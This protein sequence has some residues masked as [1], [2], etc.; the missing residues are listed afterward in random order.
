M[1]YVRPALFA[2][3]AV[4]VV[5][6][7]LA[8]AL[9]RAQSATTGTQ[10]LV[11][12]RVIDGTGAQPVENATIIVSDGRIQ[13]VGRGVPI[14]TGAIRVDLA[15]KTVMPGLINAHGHLNADVSDRPVAQKLA[16]QL[17]VYADYGVTTVYVLGTG[18]Q[19]LSDAVRLRDGQETG[20]LDR[21]RLFVAGPSLRDL[22]TQEEARSAVNRYADARVDIIKIHITGGPSDMTPS[23]Y[24]ALIDQ[25]HKR[26]LRV[27]AHLYYL[28]DAR[29]L[30]DAGV[31]VMAHSIRDRDLDPSVV[32]TMKQRGIGY[33]PTFTR[34]L[35]QFVYESTPPFFT[36]P[37]FNRR[38]DAFAREVGLA[39]DP[40]R[41]ARTR[42]NPDVQG[43]K[44]AL[45]QGMKNLKILSDGGVPIA[46]GTDSGTNLGQWQGYFEHVELEYMVKAGLTPLQALVAATGGAARVMKLD[47]LGTIQP[48]KMAD[49]LVLNADPLADILNT[50]Q[51]HSVWM[52]GR[53]LAVPGTN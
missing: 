30:L 15:G 20:A 38:Q 28:E 6:F 3:A 26:G 12:A 2:T 37:F 51:I 9:L 34:D 46:M 53:R 52:G 24:G 25:A 48:G 45:A 5:W 11:G 16:A 47:Q 41:Q 27:A 49:L 50:R 36:D 44:A 17:R 31:D 18:A 8:G 43:V 19:D 21:A 35:A 7:G 42:A 4:C 29:G 10:A 22:K 33:I 40:A 32:A 39:R 1:K 14:P 13:A 23:V